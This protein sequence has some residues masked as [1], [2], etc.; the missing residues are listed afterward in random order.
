MIETIPTIGI[1]M[2]TAADWGQLYQFNGTGDAGLI[3]P[4]RAYYFRDFFSG[5]W[6]DMSIGIIHCECGT[7]GSTSALVNERQLED[8]LANLFNFGI[9]QSLSSA[10]DVAG[11]PNF[12]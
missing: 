12:V 6:N 3:L 10:I 5:Q 9:S 7:S 11:N 4:P 2:P 1:A 8:N